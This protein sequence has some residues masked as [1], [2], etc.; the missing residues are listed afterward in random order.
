MEK[1]INLF[2]GILNWYENT[3]VRKGDP[4]EIAG[5]KRCERGMVKTSASF[6]LVG[7]LYVWIESAIP[8]ISGAVVTVL[9]PLIALL[10]QGVAYAMV[11]LAIGFIWYF[12]K[13]MYLFRVI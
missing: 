10:I 13:A 5:L 11:A 9:G 8:Q 2:I 1:I 4:D 7:I 3:T 12:A 6:L